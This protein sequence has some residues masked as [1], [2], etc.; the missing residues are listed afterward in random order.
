MNIKSIAVAATLI[1]GSLTLVSC[2]RT[3]VRVTAGS[4]S[5]AVD[6]AAVKRTGP[7]PHAPAHGYRQKHGGAVLIYQS[8]LGVYIVDKHEGHFYYKENFYRSHGGSWQISV[9][10]G[11]PWKT[12]PEKKVPHGLRG[13]YHAKAKGKNKK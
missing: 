2:S 7:P 9:A 6:E 11:G 1:I 8:S 3:A 13:E 5:V 4:G 12:I 10:I